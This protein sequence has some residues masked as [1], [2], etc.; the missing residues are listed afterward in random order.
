MKFG[1]VEKINGIFQNVM[2]NNPEWCTDHILEIINEILHMAS[3]IKKK[4]DKNP[5]AT[6]EGSKDVKEI[7]T[8]KQDPMELTFPQTIYDSFLVN[9]HSFFILLSASDIAIVEKAAQNILAFIHFS[10]I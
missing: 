4:K 8:H 7:D 3:E 1:V 10:M 9:Y 5:E 6:F 2:G